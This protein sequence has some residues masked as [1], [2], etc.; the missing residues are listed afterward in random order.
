MGYKGAVNQR[1][2]DGLDPEVSPNHSWRHT[3]K[4]RAARASIEPRIRDA[5]CGHAPKVVGDEYETPETTDLIEAMKSFPR[6]DLT[7]PKEALEP[8]IRAFETQLA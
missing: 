6:Y 3:F 4:R 5:M 7:L 1:F 8:I 2:P